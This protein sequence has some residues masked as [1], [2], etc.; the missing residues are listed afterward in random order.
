MKSKIALMAIAIFAGILSVNA[1]GMQRR[2]VEERVKEIME[3]LAPLKLDKEQADKTNVIFTEQFKGQE[4]MMED[5]RNSG[6]FDREA[7]MAFRTK[8]N[9]ERNVKLK[10]VFTPEQF[11]IF[12]KDIEPSLQPQRAPGSGGNRNRN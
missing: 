1:Q 11:A 5:I 2:T 9:E 3:K 7:M 10:T 6:N 4:K 8:S 12:T